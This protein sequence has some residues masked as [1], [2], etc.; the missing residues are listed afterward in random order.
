MLILCLTRL[1]YEI[2]KVSKVEKSKLLCI[3]YPASS[4]I[5]KKYIVHIVEIVI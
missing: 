5:R 3:F 2:K 1:K 4:R